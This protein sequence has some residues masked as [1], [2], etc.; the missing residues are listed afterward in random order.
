ATQLHVSLAGG[1]KTMSALVCQALSLLGRA[2]DCLSHVL[3]EPA[4]LENDPD[5]WWPQPDATTA[6]VR[7]HCMPFLRIG[8]W[9][10]PERLLPANATFQQAVDLANAALLANSLRI[11]L[12]RASIAVAGQELELAPSQ[13]AILALAALA[14]LR[15][16]SL[17]T[18]TGW[19]AQDRSQ[20][21]LALGGDRIAAVR[22]WAWLLAAAQY[23][24]IY[25]DAATVSFH[26]F[27]AHLD[28]LERA[29]DYD[30]HI[31]P[32]LSRLRKRLREHLPARLAARLLPKGSMRIDLPPS[33]LAITAPDDLRDHPA[34][35]PELYA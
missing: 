27:D 3:I 2:Q 23:D 32:P 17:S 34:A 6:V 19:N 28:E 4:A 5:F 7:L 10:E 29:F 30:T 35:P 1:R 12:S 21:G 18:V 8:A 25:R 9:L 11:D 16:L 26:R 15:G 14:A 20:R 13:L 31:G 22:L 24:E 33:G